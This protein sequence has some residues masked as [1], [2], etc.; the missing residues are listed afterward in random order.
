MW[1]NW[2]KTSPRSIAKPNDV[3][4]DHCLNY[5]EPINSGRSQYSKRI[6][7]DYSNLIVTAASYADALTR[8]HLRVQETLMNDGIGG[9]MAY[10]GKEYWR[11]QNNILIDDT[12]Q[13]TLLI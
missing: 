11:C 2:V 1:S 13:P 5:V 6:S 3:R 12:I 9:D 7:Q 8:H 4:N 10:K